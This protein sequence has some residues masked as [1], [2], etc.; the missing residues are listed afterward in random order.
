MRRLAGKLSNAE[1]LENVREDLS[2]R[3]AGAVDEAHYGAFPAHRRLAE[4]VGIA[5][6]EIAECLAR[7]HVEEVVMRP[8]A[9]VESYVDN[10]RFLVEI[11][12]EHVLKELLV[13]VPV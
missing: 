6:L 2:V 1:F 3:I 11:Q 9:A 10:H 12:P 7:Q 8:A 4:P 5:V 13:A